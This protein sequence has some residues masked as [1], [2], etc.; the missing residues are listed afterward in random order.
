MLKNACLINNPNP[1]LDPKLT[2]K[3]DWNPDLEKKKNYGST[4]LAGSTHLIIGIQY[5]WT[6][7]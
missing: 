6:F 1:E 5:A 2:V 4:T 3:L 7:Y